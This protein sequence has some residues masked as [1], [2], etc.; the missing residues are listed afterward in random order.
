MDRLDALLFGDDMGAVNLR[1]SALGSEIGDDFSPPSPRVRP[2]RRT[3]DEDDGHGAEELLRRN[4][5]RLE[6]LHVSAPADARGGGGV[7]ALSHLP[8]PRSPQQME[9]NE[10]E[11]EELDRLLAR[12]GMP[13]AGEGGQIGHAL[14]VRSRPRPRESNG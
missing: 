6:R 2:A 3:E 13:G 8:W 14:H 4:R 10:D 11:G 5:R 1:D 7:R 9:G 12:Y